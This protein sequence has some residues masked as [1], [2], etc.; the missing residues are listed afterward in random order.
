MRSFMPISRIMAKRFLHIDISDTLQTVYDLFQQ[1]TIDYIPVT[2]NGKFI[3]MIKRATLNAVRPSLYNCTV[4]KSVISRQAIYLS[5][6]TTINSAAEVFKSNAFK[7]I[8]VVDKHEQL[9][10]IVKPGH[11]KKI[12]NTRPIGIKINKINPGIFRL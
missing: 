12:F 11:L 6:D 4:A 5:P 7:F 3:G 2:D 1:Y 10:G 8:P 9:V